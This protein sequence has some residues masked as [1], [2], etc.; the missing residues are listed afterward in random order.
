MPSRKIRWGKLGWM[1]SLL[2]ASLV[3]QNVLVSTLAPIGEVDVRSS[4][5]LLAFLFCCQSRCAA[6][7]IPD[8]CQMTPRACGAEFIWCQYRRPI[9]SIAVL[10]VWFHPA[11]DVRAGCHTEVSLAFPSPSLSARFPHA[12]CITSC[13]CAATAAG[14][15]WGP[16]GTATIPNTRQA[17]AA[18]GLGRDEKRNC[19]PFNSNTQQPKIRFNFLSVVLWRVSVFSQNQS[20]LIQ[21]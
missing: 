20:N 11:S 15:A 21:N 7:S 10:R 19:L 18:H 4:G 12:T 17:S 2:H 8:C 16:G 3:L 6:P 13:N 5:N 14:S 9:N 1:H